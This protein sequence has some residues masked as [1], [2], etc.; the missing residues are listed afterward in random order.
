MNSYGLYKDKTL[1]EASIILNKNYFKKSE[2]LD[3]SKILTTNL[4]NF[5]NIDIKIYFKSNNNTKAFINK[6]RNDTKI[7]TYILED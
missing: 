1:N 6:N 2:I 5:S 4:N 7:E 3:I